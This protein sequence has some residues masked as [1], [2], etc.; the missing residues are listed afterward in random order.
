MNHH[1]RPAENASTL[2]EVAPATAGWQ[3]LSFK[4]L[5]LKAG[6]TY[7]QPTG[8][9]EVAL[10]PLRGQAEVDVSGTR[11][12]LAREGVFAGLPSVLYAPP[13]EMLVV[14]AE[15]SFEFAIG[16][17]P[18]EGRYPVRLFQ[19]AEMR[20]EIRGGG[21]A[22]RQV[23]HIL[24]HPLPAERLILFDVYV[25]GGAWSGWP[26]H[27]HDGYAGSA[28]LEEVYYYRI[29]P[30]EGFALHR[31]YRRDNDFDERF[32]VRNGDLVLV[33]QGFHPVAAAPGCNVY[34]LNYLAGE[35]Q[36]ELRATPPYDD[37]DFAWIKGRWE[38]NLLPLPVETAGLEG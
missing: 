18:A 5:A 2:V 4:V 32:V 14:R 11:Y 24:A 31:N 7:R 1:I 23:N 33:T 36:D 29:E 20:A 12:R 22:R 8:S 34:F 30:D 37:P 25:P 27:C 9:N 21:A 3:Y 16:G 10:V 13:G 26:P 15:G 19:P 35:L 6:E 28:Y 38:D 17:A